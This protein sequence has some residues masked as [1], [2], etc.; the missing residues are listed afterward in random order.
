MLSRTQLTSGPALAVAGVV[1]AAVVGA[2]VVVTRPF[3]AHAATSPSASAAPGSRQQLPAASAFPKPPIATAPAGYRTVTEAA[4]GFSLAVPNGWKRTS[5]DGGTLFLYQPPTGEA[6]FK[7]LVIGDGSD[8]D[9]PSALHT[10]QNT[11][12]Q[13][14][15]YHGTKRIGDI[16]GNTVLGMP[17]AR[18][19]STAIDVKGKGKGKGKGKAKQ[20]YRA[21]Q[22]FLI[23]PAGQEWVLTSTDDESAAGVKQARA[24]FQTLI[25]SFRFTENY[26]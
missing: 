10:A 16:T 12:R 23:D 9:P 24:R 18:Y 15:G 1:A 14:A 25:G 13:L 26:G 4:A 20:P 19:E 5:E 21:V 3:D 8:A 11:A 2:G 6:M 7:V 17:G 22:E